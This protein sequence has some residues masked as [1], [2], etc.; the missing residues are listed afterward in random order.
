MGELKESYDAARQVW[1]TQSFRIG[2]LMLIAP[3]V[4]QAQQYLDVEN[5]KLSQELELLRGALSLNEDTKPMTSCIAKL[6][7]VWWSTFVF[8]LEASA[9]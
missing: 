2:L 1:R 8:K 5:Q 4:A 9:L 6:C 3:S 7:P